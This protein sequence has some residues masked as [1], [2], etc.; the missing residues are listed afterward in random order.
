MQLIVR[1]GLVYRN[2][3]LFSGPIAPRLGLTSP[4][5]SKSFGLAQPKKLL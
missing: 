1:R 3:W 2:G 5:S 4:D